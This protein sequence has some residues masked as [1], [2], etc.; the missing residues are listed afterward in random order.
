MHTSDDFQQRAALYVGRERD[1]RH[2]EKGLAKVASMLSEAHVSQ[3]ENDGELV[4]QG[5]DR[6]TRMVE[7]DPGLFRK[8]DADHRV[9]F[10]PGDPTTPGRMDSEHASFRKLAVWET[11]PAQQLFIA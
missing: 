4:V 5:G 11:A 8:E 2:E 1:N 10:T 9:L 7:L 3:G 6:A